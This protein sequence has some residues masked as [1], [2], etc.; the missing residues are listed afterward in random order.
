MVF[1]F[2]FCTLNGWEGKAASSG[3]AR[4]PSRTE[5]P[6]CHPP[7]R[8]GR[9]EAQSGL[10]LRVMTGNSKPRTINSKP[11]NPPLRSGPARCN[12]KE[13]AFCPAY[14]YYLSWALKSLNNILTV[15][16]KADTYLIH[17]LD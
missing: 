17:A 5:T 8:N 4:N 3:N 12:P 11:Q 9:V 15:G 13:T 1:E 7:P 10:G 14:N 16:P 2:K 6:R